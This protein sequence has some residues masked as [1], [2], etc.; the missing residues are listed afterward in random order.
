M[1]TARA[2]ALRWLLKMLM[3]KKK[4]LPLT[5]NDVV[6]QSLEMETSCSAYCSIVRL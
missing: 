1:V 2:T 5:V 4:V 6:P 3:L